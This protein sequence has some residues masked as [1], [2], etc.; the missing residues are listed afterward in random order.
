MS[1]PPQT[2]KQ[3]RQERI[4]ALLRAN[5]A[6]RVAGLARE[7]GVSTRRCAATSTSSARPAS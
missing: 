5:P 2:R 7:F 6:V 1:A 4:I 3:A